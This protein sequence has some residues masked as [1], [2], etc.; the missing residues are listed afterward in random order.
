MQ[1][2][3]IKIMELAKQTK[4]KSLEDDLRDYFSGCN[5]NGEPVDCPFCHYISAN[6]RFSGKVWIKDGRKIFKCFSCGQWRKLNA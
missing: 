5:T 2:M 4:M 1:S 6:K 3:N